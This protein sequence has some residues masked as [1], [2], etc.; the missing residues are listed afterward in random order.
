[1]E[2]ADTTIDD[3]KL[4]KCYTSY[5]Q[6]LGINSAEVAEVWTSYGDLEAVQKV[7]WLNGAMIVYAAH[8]RV[9]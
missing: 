3:L 6:L 2:R 5:R 4:H 9:N 7:N 1:M 8:G